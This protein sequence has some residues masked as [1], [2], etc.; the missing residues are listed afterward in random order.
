MRAFLSVLILIFSLQSWTK[1]EDIR[2]FEIE[3]MSIGDSLLDYLKKDEIRKNYIGKSSKKFVSSYNI[4]NSETYDGFQFHYKSLDKNFKLYAISG[5]IE[6]SNSDIQ[7]CHKKINKIYSEIKNMFPNAES[8]EE[9]LYDHPS[10]QKGDSKVFESNFVLDDGSEIK[11]QCTK[12]SK[13]MQS[14][15]NWFSHLRI[16]VTTKE[17]LDW[18]DEVYYN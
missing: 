3:G 10:D 17:F 2:D 18:L 1:A 4:I 16:A 11:L 12:W 13:E 14:E 7:K 8:E 5:I 15:H 6:Y 9:I